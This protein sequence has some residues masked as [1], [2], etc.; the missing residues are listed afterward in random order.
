MRKQLIGLIALCAAIFVAQGAESDWFGTFKTVGP[1]RYADGALVLPGE[2]YVLVWQR[3][4]TTFQGFRE[5]GSLVNTED[6]IR[7]NVSDW[8]AKQGTEG[9]SLG[10]TTITIPNSYMNT[11]SLSLYVLDSRRYSGHVYNADGDLV[12]VSTNVT[13]GAE[14]AVHSYA[15]V[16]AYALL[17]SGTTI[18]GTTEGKTY[19]LS[20]IDNRVIAAPVITGMRFE[21]EYVVLTV[22]SSSPRVTYDAIG[23]A[24]VSATSSE[25]PTSKAVAPVSGAAAEDATIE[26]RLRRDAA[27]K[28]QFFRVIRRQL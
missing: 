27:A 20:T 3:A 5:D 14:A 11:G 1:D 8:V 28:S 25:A 9:C 7:L 22:S 13:K 21:G 24:D 17:T 2:S 10:R 6:S 23:S 12:S 4:N 15:E 19:L 18:K 16:A 26:I